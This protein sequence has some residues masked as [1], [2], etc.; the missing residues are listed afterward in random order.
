MC[1]SFNVAW[2]GSRIPC[3]QLS[4]AFELTFSKR[5]SNAWLAFRLARRARIS[6]G[7]SGLGRAG[8]SAWRRSRLL[9][10]GFAAAASG[11]WLC[12]FLSF[13]LSFLPTSHPFFYHIVVLPQCRILASARKWPKSA[14]D[15]STLLPGRS[16][17][18]AP[19]VPHLHIRPRCFVVVGKYH[20]P[21]FRN[22]LGVELVPVVNAGQ[23]ATL[24]QRVVVVRHIAD[25][26]ALVLLMRVRQF[27]LLDVV[28]RPRKRGYR[29]AV[30]IVRVPSAVIEVQVRVDDDIDLVR[31]HAS[32]VET[33]HQPSLVLVDRLSLLAQLRPD[34][35]FDQ[36]GPLSVAH[37]QRVRSDGKHIARV[38][39]NALFPKHL[40]HH[41][42]HC[43]TVKLVSP[44]GEDRQFV[45]AHRQPMHNPSP[46]SA[47]LDRP[48]FTRTSPSCLSSLARRGGRGVCS[49]ALLG[50]G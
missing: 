27:A 14:R 17:Y 15:L 49:S 33:L 34:A 43:S 1:N 9:F 12:F 26:V 37:Q 19:L 23:R 41:A 3:S 11:C 8:N 7:F 21:L 44:V 10:A 24:D 45:V 48:L 47:N 18:R 4:T 22:R 25:P 32:F 42:E 38:G 50:I 36:H 46:S 13:F 16:R 5:A 2:R 29:L 31:R 35:R 20:Q 30:A 6:A 28:L 39:S 40:G